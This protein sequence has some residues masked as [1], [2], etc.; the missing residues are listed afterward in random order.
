MF[1]CHFICVSPCS[2]CFVFFLKRKSLACQYI[3][4]KK[5]L[6][7]NRDPLT[8]SWGYR[9]ETKKTL[10]WLGENRA[11]NVHSSWG[12]RFLQNP[13]YSM[14][15]EKITEVEFEKRKPTR[16]RAHPRR[17]TTLLRHFQMF[18]RI[19]SSI[20]CS[21]TWAYPEGLFYTIIR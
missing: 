5:R 9:G 19:Q 8:W 2:F 13:Y 1:L 14:V 11:R 21:T 3:S 18:Q 12:R 16:Y 17:W 7:H 15:T 6:L 10:D 4:I 20:E